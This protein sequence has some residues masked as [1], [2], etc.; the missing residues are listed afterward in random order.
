M[1][2]VIE[3][4]LLTS[5]TDN[6]VYR[7]SSDI[8]ER[9][10]A[11]HNSDSVNDSIAV[12]AIV[13]CVRSEV[14]ETDASREEDLTARSLPKLTVGK[15]GASPRSPEVFDAF[16]RVVEGEGSTDQDDGDDDGKAHGPVHNTTSEADASE[17]ANPDK[18]PGEHHPASGLSDHCSA[19]KND[20][21][22]IVT[23]LSGWDGILVCDHVGHEVI[24]CVP[25]P[26]KRTV[27]NLAGVLL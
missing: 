5:E 7:K 8:L 22:G 23:V 19:W 14:S 24:G 9:N 26:R 13:A 17:D 3:R 4:A 18:K 16:T 6:T 21:T 15:L 27:G 11:R 1:R 20:I 2:S 10:V 12:L 25:S